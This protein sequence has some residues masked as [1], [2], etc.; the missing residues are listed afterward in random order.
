MIIERLSHE[1]EV[2]LDKLVKLE[3]KIDREVKD[4][5]PN[6]KLSAK[7]LLRY[8]VLRSIDLREFH[9]SLSDMGLSSIRSAEGYVFSNLFNVVRNLKLIQGASISDLPK[10][11][12]VGYESAKRITQNHVDMLFDLKSSDSSSKI[13]VTLPDS[14]A[15]NPGVVFELAKSGMQI[16]RINLSHGS[17]DIW[18]RMI[19]NIRRIEKQKGISIPVYMDLPGPKLRTTNFER[20]NA[21]GKGK[22]F[23]RIRLGERLLV[24]HQEVSTKISE[25]DSNDN[26]IELGEVGVAMSE[27]ITDVL[28]G[29]S[30]FFDDGM[31][32]A[33]V[34]SKSPEHI[35]IEITEAHKTKLGSQKGINLPE[36]K[37]NLPALT[38]LDIS[39]LP[40]AKQHADILG[41]SFV[42]KKADVEILYKELGKLQAVDLGIVFKIEQQN[43]VENFVDI[44]LTGMSHSRIG[45]MIARG[46]LAVE[47]GFDR[48]SEVQE[49]LLW[50]CEAAHVP[51]IWATQVLE[52]LAKNGMP[53]RAEI[54]DVARSAH[55]DCV[56]LNKGEYINDAIKATRNIISRMQSHGYKKK[57]ELRP[58]SIARKGVEFLESIERQ[59]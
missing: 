18:L 25:F 40:F 22:D 49:E 37:L 48:I 8:V 35:E 14:A 15:E 39:L 53:T 9:D 56:M 45:V 42:R 36:S 46:D 7:N 21:K 23:I 34:I 6:Y 4:L 54:S 38:S 29:E 27:I 47:I 43:A 58:L 57:S 30:V 33:R 20:I 26:Q 12:L 16:A 3:K 50:I 44:I 51:V 28:I 19:K 52:N 13:M 2:I 24:K 11:E 10:V 31:I 1:L 41:Y 55:A 5:H 32:K 59:T 17:K